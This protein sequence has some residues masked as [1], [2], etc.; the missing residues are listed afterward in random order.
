M[1]SCNA[2]RYTIEHLLKVALPVSQPLHY[3][4]G[5]TEHGVMLMFA[6]D[7]K[8][9]LP[10]FSEEELLD[11]YDG[12]A[13]YQL[14]DS[15]DG[16][17]QL[18]VFYAGN[19]SGLVQFDLVTPSFILLSREEET[20]GGERDIHDRFPYKG[21]LAE[22]YKQIGNAVPPLLAKAVFEKILEYGQAVQFEV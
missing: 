21:S 10:L 19:G 9:L 1:L 15:V 12:Q 16:K 17:V 2:I 3:V 7:K 6:P 4:L 5:L 8:M 14:V 18:P 20:R 13:D 22:K 11:F